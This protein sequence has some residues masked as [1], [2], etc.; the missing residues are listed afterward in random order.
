MAMGLAS[1]NPIPGAVKQSVVLIKPQQQDEDK[2]KYGVTNDYTSNNYIA[3]DSDN[4]PQ[5][6]SMKELDESMV[7][8][9][10]VKEENASDIFYK[11]AEMATHPNLNKALE[12]NLYEVF[13]NH[14]QYVEDQPNYDPL[15]ERVYMDKLEKT[16]EGIEKEVDNI[17]KHDR[18][19][20]SHKL[21]LD[22]MVTNKG[23]MDG[24]G[25]C[26]PILASADLELIDKKFNDIIEGRDDSIV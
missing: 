23:D 9:Y 15:L 26:F 16:F 17:K 21:S 14:T 7:D 5:I 2:P 22:P 18:D 20:T 12:G 10:I 13:T 24:E 11:L 25:L 4:K 6:R 3:L 1:M 8:V 19:M